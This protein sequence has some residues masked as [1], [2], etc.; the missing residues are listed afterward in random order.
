M[1]L[2]DN[3]NVHFEK[4]RDPVA[5]IQPEMHIIESTDDP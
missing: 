3:L 1:F 5:W 2:A 4:N